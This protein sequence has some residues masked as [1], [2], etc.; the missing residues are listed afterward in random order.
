MIKNMKSLEATQK[1][2]IGLTGVYKLTLAH[3]ETPEQL[4]LHEKIERMR[5]EG[6]DYMHLVRKLN[7][8]CRTDV[9]FEKNIIPTVARAMLVDYLINTS[10]ANDARINYTALGTNVTAVSNAQTQL[11]AETYRRTVA[12]AS[13]SSNVGFVT[14][15]YSATEVV[16]T[17][18]EHGLFCDATSAANSGVMFS[19]VLLNNGNGVVKG[20]T[21]TLTIDYT[22]TLT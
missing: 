9:Y 19:R 22:I 1:Q 13:Q 21:Q 16:G 20:S 5:N 10:P 12:S 18:Y 8:M 3:L 2:S 6:C 14:A 4:A 11:V 17:F 7:A 15:F